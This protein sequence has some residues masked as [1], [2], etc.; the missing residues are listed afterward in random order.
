MGRNAKSRNISG[1]SGLAVAIACALL[2]PAAWAQDATPAKAP[3][4]QAEATNLGAVTVTA[5]K[6]EET[7]QDVP[8]AVTAFTADALDRL[9]AGRR[10]MPP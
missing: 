3:A 6:R 8:V 9:A 2:A 4:Q 5:R 7:I 1:R 10:R